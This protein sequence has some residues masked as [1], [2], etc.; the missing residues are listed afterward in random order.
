MGQTLKDLKE[1]AR[2]AFQAWME[3]DEHVNKKIVEVVIDS[4]EGAMWQVKNKIESDRK[5]EL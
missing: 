3:L 5:E 4:L 1:E 2:K